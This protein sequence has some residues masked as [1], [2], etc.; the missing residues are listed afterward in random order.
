MLY[1]KNAKGVFKLRVAAVIRREGKLL[2]L[3]EPLA[4]TYW[5]L[6]GGRA[7]M[8]ES[9]DTALARELEEE[10]GGTFE[11]GRLLWVVEDFFTHEHTRSHTIGFYYA[12]D[13]P[14]NHPLCSQEEY[15]TSRDEE[16]QHKQFHFKWW[17][18]FRLGPE[19]LFLHKLLEQGLGRKHKR[20]ALNLPKRCGGR[21]R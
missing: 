9:T 21:N 11:I 2:L 10:M 12:V 20:R 14:I 16:G 15:H 8:H 19:T 13:L 7:E 6:P 17:G 5:I 1:I 18:K 3:N 4:G